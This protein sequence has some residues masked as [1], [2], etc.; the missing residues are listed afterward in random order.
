[1]DS[2][3]RTKTNSSPRRNSEKIVL[4]IVGL[5]PALIGFGVYSFWI[6]FTWRLHSLSRV[7]TITGL[8]FPAKT[9]LVQGYDW[10]GGPSEAVEV[11]LQMPRSEVSEFLFQPYMT[12]QSETVNAHLRPNDYPEFLAHGWDLSHIH[13]LRQ[14]TFLTSS[15]EYLVVDLDHSQDAVAYVHYYEP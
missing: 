9:M 5:L 6:G 11:K 2:N 7:E 13:H 3:L 10:K 4:A 1:M 12:L 8:R 15:E 14:A